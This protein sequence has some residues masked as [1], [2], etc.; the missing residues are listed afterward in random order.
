VAAKELI[1][2]NSIAIK[3]DEETL[4]M[5]LDDDKMKNAHESNVMGQYAESTPDYVD[6]RSKV[7]SGMFGE[8]TAE[9]AP[10][11]GYVYPDLNMMRN[12]TASEYGDVTVILKDQVKDRSTVTFGD[13]YSDNTLFGDA[14]VINR[15]T[16]TPMRNPDHRSFNPETISKKVLESGGGI[17]MLDGFT[18]EY[19]YVEVQV[20]G[21]ISLSNIDRVIIPK[22]SNITDRLDAKGIR[23]EVGSG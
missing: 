2:E 7:E 3:L 8:K 12:R 9:N 4:A 19:R 15:S 10:I 13:S 18:W 22:L 20:S 17:S 1:G 14:G 6:L 23:W 11:Y 21:G 16:A 5:V